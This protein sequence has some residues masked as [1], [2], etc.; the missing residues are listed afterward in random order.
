[1]GFVEGGREPTQEL[2]VRDVQAEVFGP[3]VVVTATWFFG[4]RS[5]SADSLQ[6]GPMTAVYVWTGDGYRIAHMHFAE[7]G[8]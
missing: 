8:K 7:Y 4:D 1:M 3:T 6:R 2:W 5:A